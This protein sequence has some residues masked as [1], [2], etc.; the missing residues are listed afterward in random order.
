MLKRPAMDYSKHRQKHNL[1]HYFY[2]DALSGILFL[3][4]TGCEK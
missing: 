2:T 3:F 4:F 1:P